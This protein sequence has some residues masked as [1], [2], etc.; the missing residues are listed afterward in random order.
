VRRPQ[1]WFGA[2]VQFVILALLALTAADADLWGHLTFGRD[3]LASGHVVQVDRYS[4]TSDLPWINHEWL[5]EI[6]MAAAWRLAGAIGL[7]TLKL[8]L[9][10]GAG[11]FVLAAWRPF[12]LTPLW[13]DGLLF[14]TALGVWP[15]VATIRPQAFSILLCAAL[16]FFLIEVRAGRA[17]ARL[18]VPAL[19]AVWVN[20]HGGWLVGAGVL[21]IFTACALID[22]TL[23]LRVRLSILL[24]AAASGAAC[25]VNPYGAR[26]LD[27]LF[28]TVR[29]ERADIPE[30]RAV[31]ALPMAA[32]VLWALPM[33]VGVIALARRRRD[34]PLWV[35][36]TIAMLAIGSM[37][38]ARLGGFF[39]LAVG[40]L[41]APLAA[42]ARR[43]GDNAARPIDW[44]TVAAA[45]LA[46]A[47]ALGI[48]GR[49]VSMDG[50]WTPEPGAVEFARSHGLHGRLLTWFDYGEY[51]IWHLGPTLTV[52]MDG[53]RE[54]VYSVAVRN[55]HTEI[56]RNGPGAIVAVA[57]LRPDYI[58]LPKSL[59][60]VSHLE[61][62]GWHPHY[63]GPRSVILGLQ[64]VEPVLDDRAVPPRRDFPGP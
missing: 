47:I 16:L 49:R 40:L 59:P 46:A 17:W 53:R 3:I 12:R 13:R 62:V 25:L 58:W 26:M 57:E 2:L 43:D 54:T 48:F 23:P 10:W 44:Q 64:P 31:T 6:A 21:A 34:A 32:L 36:L 5:A 1:L 7:T 60:V 33:A 35:W 28:A 19:F 24:M 39:A 42:P 51:A 45:I 61:S 50:D 18:A 27:F 29:P 38:V 63:I 30:W 55:R 22:L 4:F 14:A 11:A 41:V 37:R 52:S 8:A 15:L 9:A 56:Y 20:A